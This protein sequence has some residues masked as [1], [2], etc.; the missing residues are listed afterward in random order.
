[1]HSGFYGVE[2]CEASHKWVAFVDLPGQ[3]HD[4]GRFDTKEVAALK[5]NEVATRLEGAHL[6]TVAGEQLAPAAVLSA[7]GVVKTSSMVSAGGLRE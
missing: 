7:N 4:I 3:T 5:Y 1:M 2:F 6:N